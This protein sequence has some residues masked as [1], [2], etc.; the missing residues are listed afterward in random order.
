MDFTFMSLEMLALA[1]LRELTLTPP[2]SN[3]VRHQIMYVLKLVLQRV[4][5]RAEEI[6]EEVVTLEERAR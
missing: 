4:W 3:M 2:I 1:S 6:D 5:H